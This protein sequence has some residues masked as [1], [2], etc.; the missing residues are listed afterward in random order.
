[1][2]LNEDHNEKVKILNES[3]QTL[4]AE[5][6]NLL[7]ELTVWKRKFEGVDKQRIDELN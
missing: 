7:E 4:K 5:V 2:N 6:N 3:I 1:M